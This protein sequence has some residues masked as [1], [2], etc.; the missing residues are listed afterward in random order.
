MG[1]P[2]YIVQQKLKR[3]KKVLIQWSRDTYGNLF[4]K[5]ATSEDVARMK[6]AQLEINRSEENKKDL[7]RT[8]EALKQYYKLEEE[9]WKQKAGMHWFKDGDRNTKFF[10]AYM[11]GRRMNLRI[12]EI[13]NDQNESPKH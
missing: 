9:Y 3:L 8:E 7:Q 12:N 2:L 4:R 11:N 10:H 5:I 6:E 13:Q 1:T